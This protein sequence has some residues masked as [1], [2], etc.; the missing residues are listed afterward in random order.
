MA[1]IPGQ[2]LIM[3][4]WYCTCITCQVVF[5]QWKQFCVCLSLP[6]STMIITYLQI[7]LI[8]A[9]HE[10]SLHQQASPLAQQA[11]PL[12]EHFQL[13]QKCFT[14]SGAATSMLCFL[15]AR[16]PPDPTLHLAPR[17]GHPLTTC[18]D[19]LK[20]LSKCF[21]LNT[22]ATFRWRRVGQC[23]R[24]SASSEVGAMAAYFC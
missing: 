23:W 12:A 18:A 11:S 10:P 13:S 5:T 17:F 8:S 19:L 7:F 15:V 4:I 2:C 6:Q 20:L 9:S 16:S 3:E 22:V 21:V 14:F 24:S 1:T